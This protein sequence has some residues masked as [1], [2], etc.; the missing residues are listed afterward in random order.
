MWFFSVLVKRFFSKILRSSNFFLKLV[1]KVCMRALSLCSITGERDDT[2][3]FTILF[4]LSNQQTDI[5]FLQ[6]EH[7]FTSSSTRVKGM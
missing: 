7:V 4:L 6:I 1:K 3:G 2:S 5:K